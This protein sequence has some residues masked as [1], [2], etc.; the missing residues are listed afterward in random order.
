MDLLYPIFDC[1]EEQILYLIQTEMMAQASPM[2]RSVADAQEALLKDDHS[3]IIKSLDTI[4]TSLKYIT[5]TS[6]AK[7]SYHKRRDSFMDPIVFTKTM[8]SFAVPIKKGVPGPSGT[9]FPYAHLID[10]FTGRKKYDEHISK[11]ALAIRK[12]YPL[13]V[14]KFLDAVS[15]ISF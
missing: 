14:R 4:I 12:F 7:L 2:V 6:F 15:K 3:N 10:I 8:M 5:N 1:R 13:H 9:A 11:E